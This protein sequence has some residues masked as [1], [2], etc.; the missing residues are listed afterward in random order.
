[1]AGPYPELAAAL[2]KSLQ[3]G[4]KG[5]VRGNIL[6]LRRN[7]EGG[8][9]PAMPEMLRQAGIG[10]LDLLSASSTGEITPEAGEFM[11]NLTPAGGLSAAV[12]PSA[13]GSLGIFGGRLAKTADPE[14]LA[15][16]ETLAALGADRRKIWDDTGW[17]QGA[18]GKWRFEIDDNI[19]HMKG[20]GTASEL[21]DKRGGTVGDTFYHHDLYEAYPELRSYGFRGEGGRGGN[22]RSGDLLDPDSTPTI[23][24]GDN[25]EGKGQRSVMLHELTHGVQD[26]ENFARGAN[27][28]DMYKFTPAGI[29]G[30]TKYLRG[31]IEHEEKTLAD[32]ASR[33]STKVLAGRLLE[34]YRRELAEVEGRE[35]VNPYA[36]Y[37]RHAGETEARNV[38][39]R[40]D[41]T[42]DQRRATPP[43]ETQDVPDEQQ[44]V[45]FGA[46][47]PS[48]MAALGGK[49]DALPMDEASR[50]ARALEQGYDTDAYHGT[51]KSFDEFDPSLTND[52]GMHFGTQGQANV[53]AAHPA[54]GR[55]M[56]GANVIPAKLKIQN[57]LR[58]GDEFSTL[59]RQ[60]IARAKKLTL[61]TPGFRANEAER[62][63][64]Y[65]AA[66]QADKARRRGGGDWNIQL[67]K[68]N[69]RHRVAYEDAG[70]RFW[71][72]VQASA[73]R[74]GY[75]GLVYSNRVEGKG[76]SYV[77]FEPSQV[78]SR[79]AAFDP[80]KRDSAN[81]LAARVGTGLG[82][83]GLL[84]AATEGKYGKGPITSLP[85]D[86]ASR[87]A[88]AVEQGFNTDVY[89]GTS[90]LRA[91]HHGEP[92]DKTPDIRSFEAKDP[93]LGA[94]GVYVSRNPADA[95]AF[96]GDYR[97][98]T[99]AVYPLKA[100]GNLASREYY[101]ALSDQGLRVD[102]IVDRMKKEG[103]SGF[104]EDARH[105]GAVIFDPKNLRSRFAAFD[106]KKTDSSDLLAA[107][108]GTG[109]GP[110]GLLQAM[111][112]DPRR[113]K[114]DRLR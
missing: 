62:A 79:F 73:K 10:L 100:R 32:P 97:G 105:D 113:R 69:E 34:R 47:G 58:V 90:G 84:K 102:E 87:S 91:Q 33:E 21:A 19:S 40:R 76:D 22:F 57:P 107:R 66:K 27:P 17:F 64:I 29:Q 45:R 11:T 9:R 92:S 106:P 75:D 3:K 85:M 54:T 86:E 37:R 30:K 65:E 36:A 114:Q 82:P 48:L 78:R 7:S 4:D 81:L 112:D 31:Q 46:G 43:W 15:Q 28:D 109:T 103:F 99:G 60:F 42:P 23:S 72:T 51:T 53:A 25:L 38:Q 98:I 70:K 101:L 52:I 96:A 12:R 18:D 104:Y 61:E 59:G 2:R 41:M 95:S 89:H 67:N 35:G 55:I 63:A 88:R 68:D 74:Q 1:M 24:I 71:D 20:S 110:V 83:V 13:A 77:V 111:Q 50:M 94:P 16:A 26:Q 39:T 14:K 56:D 93:G 80:A 49:S 44:I 108:I 5:E 8:L 6:P